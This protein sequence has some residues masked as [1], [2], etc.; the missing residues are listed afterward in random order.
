MSDYVAV[1]GS[2]RK[3][4]HN[5][6]TLGENREFI[7]EGTVKGFGM[8]SLGAYPALTREGPHTDVVVELYHVDD[9]SMSALDTLE[10]FP[11]YYTRKLCP[12]TIEGE[13][14]PAWVYYMKEKLEEGFVPNGDWVKYVRSNNA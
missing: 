3:G 14:V 13:S 12:I 1:Y 4:L 6:H 7:G 8:Y 10:G 9:K 11:H 2:L 5:H